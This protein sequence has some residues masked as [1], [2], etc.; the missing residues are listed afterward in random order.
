I[1]TWLRN[2]RLKSAPA[3]CASVMPRAWR[4]FRMRWPSV[5]S[6]I[7][8]DSEVGAGVEGAGGA[9]VVVEATRRPHARVLD[10]DAAQA[11]EV[12][13]GLHRDHVALHQRVLEVPQEG[14]LVHLQADAVARGVDQAW[15]V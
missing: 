6:L 2:A 10:P 1:S 7:S 4:T 14:C 3:T 13:A 8:S 11:L 9:R 5:S 15:T 12:E